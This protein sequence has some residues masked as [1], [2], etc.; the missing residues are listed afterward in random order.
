MTRA[1]WIGGWLLVGLV[2]AATNACSSEPSDA[3]EPL[4]A[5]ARPGA[6]KE[7]PRCD[8]GIPNGTETD[9]DCGG[10]CAKCDLGKGCGGAEDCASGVCT[11][12]L[13]MPATSNDGVQ[14]AGETDVDC[15]GD[16]ATAC[17]NGMRCLVDADCEG[18]LCDAGVCATRPADPEPEDEA[19]ADLST[20]DFTPIGGFPT[21][22]NPTEFVPKNAK[23]CQGAT[24]AGKTTCG[25]NG[26]ENCCKTIQVPGGTYRRYK[27]ANLVAKVS[28]FKLDKFEVTQGRMRAF[29]SAM[30]GNVRAN[31]PAPGAGA[32]PNVPGSGWRSEW[33]KRLPQSWDEIYGRL[34][35]GCAYGSDNSSYGSTTWDSAAN[36]SKAITCIDWYTLYAFCIWDGGTLPSDTQWGF[37]AMGGAEERTYTWNNTPPHADPESYARAVTYLDGWW[38]TWPPPP[39]EANQYWNAPDG[40]LHIAPPGRKPAGRA[41]WGHMDLNGNVLEWMLDNGDVKTGTCND[42]ANVSYPALSASESSRYPLNASGTPAW[43]SDGGRILRGGS[44]EGHPLQNTHKYANYPVWRTYARAGGRCARF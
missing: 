14:N 35:W 31:A 34:V 27:N 18:N 19:G 17:A 40:P 42:C 15:G 2:A 33:N 39:P 13:C 11:D 7:V 43:A 12:G 9:T 37:A 25:S 26:S 36:D 32:H 22:K 8:D 16:A 44:W 30:G 10:S 1:R 21:K 23:S 4:P 38:M 28:P 41:R 6:L 29:F 20:Q 24:G 5:A 3:P